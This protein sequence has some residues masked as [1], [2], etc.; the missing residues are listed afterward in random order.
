MVDI[1]HRVGVKGSSPD[2]VYAALDD[3]RRAGRLVDDDTTGDSERRRSHQFRFVALGGI[4]MKVLEL[5]P[6]EARALGGRRRTRRSGSARPSASTSK[7]DGDFTIVLFKHEGWR[8]PV[9]FMHHCSTKWG[10]FLL[11]LK[12]LARDRRRAP[13][14]PR[15]QDRLL[16]LDRGPA[17]RR[18]CCVP[19]PDGQARH[20]GARHPCPLR[21]RRSP[22]R[23]VRRT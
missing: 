16:E 18:C 6:A 13:R 9:E 10:T 21:C 12:A 3:D 23:W 8:E 14:A 19:D 22:P 2:D 17:P 11:S 4:D 7:Q 1:L 15:R 20:S 5:E